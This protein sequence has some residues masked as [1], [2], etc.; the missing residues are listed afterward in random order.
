[1][2]L[3]LVMV[4]KSLYSK[5]AETIQTEIDT[6]INPAIQILNAY[7]SYNKELYLIALNK[8]SK[9]KNEKL[10]N[11]MKIITEVE[12]PH[13]DKLAFDLIATFPKW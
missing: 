11:R 8:I 9:A 12:L 5:K 7:R 1:M 6:R 4:L 2:V 3:L 10:T 13:L